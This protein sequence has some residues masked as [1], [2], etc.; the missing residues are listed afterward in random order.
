MS[1]ISS[2]K[3][4]N[5]KLASARHAKSSPRLR[6]G[7][8]SLESRRLLSAVDSQVAVYGQVPLSFEPNLGQT[9]GQVKFLS[10]GNGYSLFLTSGGAVLSLRGAGPTGTVQ[11]PFPQAPA[12]SVLTME[13]VD[14]NPTSTSAG[15]DPL[16][17]VSNYLTGSDS[18]H[19]YT[20]VPE[21]A[22]VAYQQV[23]P[24]VDL[25]YYGNQGQLEYDFQVAPGA[26]P[27]AI[28]L[29]FDGAESLGVNTTGDLVI[30][31]SG[32]DVT[33]HAPVI[34]QTIGGIKQPVSGSYTLEGDDQVGFQLGVYDH[35]EPLCVDPVLVYSTYLGGTG[36]G[37]SASAVA[38]DSTGSSYV[39]G[40]TT[41]ID[42]PGAGTPPASAAG[43]KHAFVT[44]FDPTGTKI[45][46]STYLG[47]SEQD[48]G[49]GIAVDAQG[50]AYVTGVTSSRD[51]PGT[52]LVPP[53]RPVPPD[54]S[55][56]FVTELD[57]S[58]KPVFSVL[59]T[60]QDA[61]LGTIDA[62]AIAIDSDGNA[63]I[64]GSVDEPDLLLVN[65]FQDGGN[66]GLPD[67]QAF[68]AEIKAGGTGVLFSTYL[69]SLEEGDFEWSTDARAIA[70][71]DSGHAYVTGFTEVDDFPIAADP[72]APNGGGVLHATPG[73]DFG[74]A[75]ITKF[76]AVNP[77]KEANVSLVYSTYLARATQPARRRS[78]LTRMEMPIST[79]IHTRPISGPQ[80][81]RRRH[82]AARPTERS[83]RRRDQSLRF[84]APGSKLHKR[85][86]V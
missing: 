8:E 19:W 21:Y 60:G 10:Q 74:D 40:F 48:S 80:A 16:P 82:Q 23:Y 26:D 85:K 29:K 59:L 42:F 2:R 50:D 70:V 86:Y 84:V 11:D 15:I 14:A 66:V 12:T 47:G 52:N 13:L 73:S 17:G 44:R 3:R 57:K 4:W 7:L 22:R 62:E 61:D 30:A 6:P 5:R 75:F 25:D 69:G 78:R 37:D 33:E 9:D 68:V 55:V 28:A 51:F 34:Y 18:S 67:P 58:G 56:A 39:T 41:S 24:G 81:P 31:T 76:S 27:G 54:T 49:N 83:L 35:S 71:D 65:A 32:G 20:D 46:Y 79:A 43:N 38:V 36:M 77:T 45:L 53:T 63:Y 64:A 1:L 72:N